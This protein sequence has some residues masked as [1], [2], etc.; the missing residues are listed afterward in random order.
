ME[1]LDLLCYDMA[2][3]DHVNELYIAQ[4]ALIFLKELMADIQ[5]KGLQC[6]VIATCESKTLLLKDLVN[7]RISHNFFGKTVII[8]PPTLVSF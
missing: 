6:V 4:R 3:S 8:S 5:E 2:E 7:P 1:N